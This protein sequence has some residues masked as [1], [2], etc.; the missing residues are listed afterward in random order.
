MKKLFTTIT[1]IIFSLSSYAD[2][3]Y[4]RFSGLSFG[5][6]IGLLRSNVADVSVF[7]V[8]FPMA[9]HLYSTTGPHVTKDTFNGGVTLGL[10]GVVQRKFLLGIEGLVHFGFNE[11][12][13]NTSIT[14]STSFLGLF[15]D[16]SIAFK[17]NYAALAKLGLILREDTLLYGL[18]GPAWGD[19]TV[20][21]SV[22]H[23]QSFGPTTFTGAVAGQRSGYQS[24]ILYGAGIEHA[25]DNYAT[26]AVEYHYTDYGRI[27]SPDNLV[28]G[29]S[30]LGIL[31]E[32]S[33]ISKTSDIHANFSNFLL[34]FNFYFH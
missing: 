28:G 33:L 4:M 7:Q 10:N 9:F 12:S 6:E 20:Q 14:D 16:T 22:S 25:L 2:C 34:K 30:T 32:D 5:A 23:T 13:S 26:V 27:K 17:Q 8:A 29:L 31:V 1:G 21:S 15:S 11:V 18:I 24:G 19:F 3:T